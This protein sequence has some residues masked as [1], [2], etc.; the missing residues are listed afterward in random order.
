M[1]KAALVGATGL[2]SYRILGS[3]TG[4]SPFAR[5][6][7]LSFPS[8]KAVQECAALPGAQET[9]AHAVEMSTGGAPHFMIVGEEG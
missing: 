8:L 2:E 9:M 4:T 7:E 1:G 3:P 6:T 5:V